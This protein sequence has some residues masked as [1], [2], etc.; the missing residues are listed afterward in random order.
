MHLTPV[1]LPLAAAACMLLMAGVFMLPRQAQTTNLAG[2]GS[3][4]F[5]AS[6]AFP[7]HSCQ[8][9]NLWSAVTFEWTKAT[10]SLSIT[11]SFGLGRTNL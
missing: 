3:S 7:D 8:Q 4:N 10:P 6:L 11:G 5:L 1:W 2:S 9:W